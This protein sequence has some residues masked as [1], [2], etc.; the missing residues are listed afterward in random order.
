MFNQIEKMY[1]QAYTKADY[2]ASSKAG[3]KIKVQVNPESYKVSHR[4]EFSDA[5]APGTSAANLRFNKIPPQDFSF[6]FLFDNTGVIKGTSLLSIAIENPFSSGNNTNVIDQIE[7][8]KHALLNYHGDIHRPY[9]LKLHWGTLTFKG[10][11]TSMDIEFKLFN[12]DGTPI[13]AVAKVNFR[14]SI[15]DN[16]RVALEDRQSPDIMHERVF[17]ADDKFTL[18]NNSIYNNEQYYIPVAKY[19]RLNSFRKI[20]Q[21]THLFFPPL[22]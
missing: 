9:F 14:G 3:D 10:V 1:I 11:M 8:F 2:S 21:G 18:M 20:K 12:P 13:R 19:N 15:D 16:L 7:N 4:V 22:I 17:G 5:Q 6:D